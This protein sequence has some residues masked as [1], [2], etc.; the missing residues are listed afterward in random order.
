MEKYHITIIELQKGVIAVTEM[1]TSQSHHM[2]IVYD[3]EV[4]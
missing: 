1:V 2:V 3:K 4:S